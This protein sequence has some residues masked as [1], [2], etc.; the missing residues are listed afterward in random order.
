[1][2][3]STFLTIAAPQA[4]MAASGDFIPDYCAVATCDPSTLYPAAMSHAQFRD[5]GVTTNVDCRTAFYSNSA[6]G[7]RAAEW[8]KKD[9][10]YLKPPRGMVSDRLGNDF[11]WT[12]TD[13]MWC[14]NSAGA[15]GILIMIRIFAHTGVTEFAQRGGTPANSNYGFFSNGPDGYGAFTVYCTSNTGAQTFPFSGVALTAGNSGPYGTNPDGTMTLNGAMTGDTAD[16]VRTAAGVPFKAAFIWIDFSAVNWTTTCG[17]GIREI[18]YWF[19]ESGLAGD[20]SVMHWYASTALQGGERNWY[21]SG[22]EVLNCAKPEYVQ[23]PDTLPVEC[24]SAPAPAPFAVACG[25]LTV[26]PST[27][28]KLA[29]CLI[30]TPDDYL[31]GTSVTSDNIDG[32]PVPGT[33]SCAPWS[34]GTLFDTPVVIDICSWY[35]PARPYFDLVMTAGLWA[36]IA[37][38]VFRSRT[39]NS[40]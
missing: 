13:P 18:A 6:P 28:S 25:G 37:A 4:A 36:G 11:R 16:V 35:M 40:Q 22:Q 27:W 24:R 29:P 8:S 14:E 1:M 30:G 7:M 10:G 26:D 38:M 33:G 19:A 3:F 39:G 15:D 5:A 20:Y 34:L 23:F 12:A 9:G 2:G 21:G 32:L 31:R 17:G